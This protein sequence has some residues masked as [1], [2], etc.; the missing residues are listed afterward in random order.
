MDIRHED[1]IG[2]RCGIQGELPL[3]QP[4]AEILSEGYDF[5]DP[6][7]HA[8]L[9]LSNVHRAMSAVIIPR[10]KTKV[11]AVETV[12]FSPR[13]SIVILSFS[14]ESPGKRSFVSLRVTGAVILSFSEG[15]LGK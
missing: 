14:E 13:G 12:V 10:R 1:L 4:P 6:V 8:I 2:T 15:S 5:S 7:F 3:T 9:P 11:N